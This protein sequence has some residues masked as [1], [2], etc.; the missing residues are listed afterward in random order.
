MDGQEDSEQ[1]RHVPVLAQEVVAWLACRPGGRYVDATVGYGGHAALILERSAPD[2][3][4]IGIDRDAAALTADRQRLQP[5]GERV[6]LIHGNFADLKRHLASAGLEEVDGVLFDLGVSSVQLDDPARGFSFLAEG[7]LDMRMDARSAVTAAT[8][9]NEL[10]EGELA[11]VI[12]QFGEERYSRRIARAI[13]RAR[14]VRPLGTTLELADVI[15]GAVP[16]PY[17]HGRIHCAT[18][19]FQ[20]LRI[21]VNRE[22]DGLEAAIRD[23]AEA[24]AP[25]G[26]LGVISFHSLEDRIVKRTLRSLAQ[27]P[28]PRL[29]V[30]TKK[31][32]IPSE[33]ER[34]A[35]PRARSAKLRVAERPVMGR[36]A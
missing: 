17:R 25:G 33:E 36:A 22:L 18:R 24:L 11:D 31:P 32:L 12:F 28:E 20:A 3:L 9:V 13:A 34:R 6:R 7:P 21:A 2:G 27:G 19:T 16:P 8:L 5:Y 1:L 14:A 30:L 29:V 26:R 35:N 23:G 15:R 4:L 10:P